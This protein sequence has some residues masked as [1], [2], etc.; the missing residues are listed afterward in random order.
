LGWQAA[1][2]A[3]ATLNELKDWDEGRYS[4]M[5]MARVIAWYELHGAVQAH[6]ESAQIKEEK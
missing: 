5:F 2:A 6:T 1:V 4:R 3:G